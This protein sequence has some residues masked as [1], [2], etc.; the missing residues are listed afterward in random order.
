M[1]AVS[2]PAEA[3]LQSDTLWA[4][5]TVSGTAAVRRAGCATAA[6][7]RA[8]LLPAATLSGAFSHHVEDL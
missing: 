2:R 3:M 1:P 8:A 7:Q 6:C 4:R 5:K